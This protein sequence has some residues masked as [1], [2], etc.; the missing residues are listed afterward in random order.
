MTTHVT[1]LSLLIVQVGTAW[2]MEICCLHHS[3]C[4]ELYQIM[5]TYVAKTLLTVQVG[6]AWCMGICSVH[7]SHQLSTGPKDCEAASGD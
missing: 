4:V 2:C 3:H 6:I 7:H 1:E 5:S